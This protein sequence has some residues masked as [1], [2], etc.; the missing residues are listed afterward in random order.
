MN[1]RVYNSKAIQLAEYIAAQ[2]QQG[3]IGTSGYLP[4]E[5]EL[6]ERYQVSRN[7]LRRALE[8]CQKKGIIRKEKNRPSI[9]IDNNSEKKENTPDKFDLKDKKLGFLYAASTDAY[10]SEL[11]GGISRYTSEHGIQL[12]VYSTTDSHSAAHVLDD[13]LSWGFDGLIVVPHPLPRYVRRINRIF[14]SG[15]P[16][17]TI[18]TYPGLV[19]SSIDCDVGGG[20]Y[21]AVNHLI[22]KFEQP[23]YYFGAVDFL[24][25]YH[26]YGEAMTSGGFADIEQYVFDCGNQAINPQS[27]P[28]ENKLM[29]PFMQAKEFL[30]SIKNFPISVLS[31]NSYMYYGL[32]RAATELHLRIPEDIRIANNGNLPLMRKCPPALIRIENDFREVGYLAALRLHALLKGENNG[33]AHVR[34]QTSLVNNIAL[35]GKDEDK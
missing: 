20:V 34:L 9:F 7:T 5:Q 2:L 23:V 22:E 15:Y 29:I 35:T 16:I 13:P 12:K 33:V 31:A 11:W 25:C 26:S 18:G 4:G 10:H 14:R 19:C 27:W 21:L 1:T 3:H 17:L 8:I 28:I 32:C 30:G 24:P 6:A